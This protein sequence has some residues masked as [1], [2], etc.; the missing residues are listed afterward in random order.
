MLIGIA[1][2]V[3]VLLVVA[4]DATASSPELCNSCH[5]MKPWV[6]S[7]RVSSHGQVECY[8]CHG[9][10]RP[11]Y[12][13]PLSIV[14]RWSR[15]SDYFKAQRAGRSTET[16]LGGAPMQ[17]PIPD[18]KCEQCHD[19]ETI[20]SKKFNVTIKH[21][22]HARKNESC[23]SCHRFVAHPD[24][25][26]TR[27]EA[28][29]AQCF[30][31]H[32]LQKG[33]KAAGRCGLCHPA[34]TELEPKSH[35]AKTWATKHGQ[36]ALVD[37]KQCSMCHLDTFCLACH[38]VVMPHPAD[39]AKGKNVHAAT[40]KHDTAV[41]RK[42]HSGSADLC[43]MCHHQGFD[44]NK[45]PWVKEHPKLASQKGPAFCFAG[46]HDALFCVKCHTQNPDTST[47]A[48]SAP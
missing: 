30:E 3:L 28:L 4:A 18:W 16:T 10:P 34:G 20:T 22:E 1:L 33:A 40:A 35:Q 38:G 48:T 32:G 45:G 11:W 31:C 44:A 6:S 27:N 2:V 24:P 26:L 37:R 43:T 41:C 42:C 15:I 39:W 47:P 23:V 8:A 5:A 19:L 7:W 29:M 36:A 25:Y 46:C 13:E 9:T 12:G 14:E 17:P 21:T